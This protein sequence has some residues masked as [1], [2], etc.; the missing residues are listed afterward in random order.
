MALINLAN[1]LIVQQTAYLVLAPTFYWRIPCDRNYACKNLV[2][3]TRHL[4]YLTTVHRG[5]SS[6]LSY[7]LFSS[8]R[9]TARLASWHL[10]IPT[11]SQQPAPPQNR[12]TN[13]FHSHPR[14]GPSIAP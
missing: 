5:C 13:L 3:T 9:F 4:L 2:E 14:V 1:A 7:H 11:M 12:L 8:L 10:R 6:L